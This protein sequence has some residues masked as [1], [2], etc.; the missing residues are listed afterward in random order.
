MAD[1][2][3][4]RRSQNPKS[5]RLRSYSPSLTVDD[6]EK[7]LEFYET[8]LG[9]HVDERW[10]EDGELKGVMLVA[11]NCHLGLSQDDF[12]KGRNRTKG[13]GVRLWVETAQNLDGLAEQFRAGGVEFDGPKDTGWGGRM[14]AVSDPDGYAIT[15]TEPQKEAEG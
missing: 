3:Q 6:I 7:S 11:G 14:L 13:V 8:G 2:S 5:L 12:A 1:P 4:D 10:E 9:F 15:F